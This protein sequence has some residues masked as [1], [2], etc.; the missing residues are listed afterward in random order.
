MKNENTKVDAFIE[1]ANKWRAEFELLRTI[2]L[3][4]QL[5]EDFKWGKPCYAFEGSNVLILQG[6]KET[7][8]VLFFK[9]ALFKD[10]EGILE[11]Q[12]K[13]T[14]GARRI[15]FKNLQEIEALEPI[16]YDYF[17]EAIAV[18]KSGLKVDYSQNKELVFPEEFIDKIDEDPDLKVAFDALTPGRQRHYTMFFTEP[19]Q[20]KT[21]V[22][23][24]EKSVARIMAGKG[25]NDR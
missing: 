1:K 24:I 21:R 19:K 2:A 15:P 16:L 4:S 3:G 18:E 8:A 25:L 17:R 11:S 12:G 5:T 23:R 13:N 22:A 6:F 10:P 7:V 9:G 14:Q 20:S